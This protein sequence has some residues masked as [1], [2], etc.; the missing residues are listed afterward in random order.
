MKAS[1]SNFNH[2]K[3]VER[4]KEIINSSDLNFEEK[5]SI[6]SRDSLTFTNG[7]YVKCSAMFVDIR[8]SKALTEK[9]KRPTLAR[10]YKSYTLE[11]VA[12][13]KCHSK[14]SEINIEGDCVWGVFD[15]PYK[16]DIQEL[17]SVSAMVSSLIDILN[18]QYEKKGYDP[19]SIGIGIDY[20]RTLMIKAGYKGSGIN[21]I[22]WMGDVVNSASALCSYGNKSYSDYETMVSNVVYNNLTD[23]DQEL[24]S[25]NSNRQCYHGNIVNV[26]MNNWLN[27]HKE[28]EQKNKNSSL[29]W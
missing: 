10:I 26:N 7:F 11:L 20:G 5:D 23:S 12:V 17:F 13:M 27:E 22:V 24:L 29:Y 9:Y 6:P 4:I 3:S 18:W 25:W 19:I 14:V 21:D 8:G 15:T 28:K 1:F 16:S 2:L